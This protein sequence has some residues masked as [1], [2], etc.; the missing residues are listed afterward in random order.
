LGIPKSTVASIVTRWKN[1]GTV[2]NKVRTGRPEKLS[3]ATK[4]LLVRNI[5]QECFQSYNY[6]FGHLNDATFCINRKTFA[7]YLKKMGFG[8]FSPARKPGL[9][10]THMENRLK[11]CKD[12]V[13]WS[14]ERWES[15][16][17]SDESK[18]TVVG[19]D[20]GTR[21]IRKTG[22]RYEQRHV[23]PTYKFGKGS[24]MVWSCFW[25]GSLGPLVVLDGSIDQDA[26]I[27]TLAK[28]FHPWY[29]N[30]AEEEG[31][32]FIFQE[33][34]ASCHTGKYATWWKATHQIK[35][36]DVWPA[37]SPDLNPIENLWAALEKRIENVR[38]RISNTEQLK[39]C[40]Q[41]EWRNLDSD[42]LVNLVASMPRRCQSVIDNN[43]GC[44]K[45]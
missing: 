3:E 37:Q 36:F 6:F 40:L 43:G 16:I 10:L 31:K 23:V 45:Y 12:K 2:V 9:T 4:R 28:D 14:Q 11:W 24:V 30:L 34:G 13:N 5:R 44:S 42:L 21:C 26:Y 32:Q 27:N 17:W 22:E 29:Q 39:A 8:S 35:G 19:N 41:N 1:R 38:H 25:S 33:D 7:A 18:F 15:V 20:R